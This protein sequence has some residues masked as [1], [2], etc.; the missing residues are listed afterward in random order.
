MF[1]KLLLTLM[2]LL[3]PV[4]AL[5][6]RYYLQ[7]SANPTV[8]IESLEKVDTMLSQLQESINKK[9]SSIKDPE[10]L[11]TTVFYATE[12]G[13]LT[14]SGVAPKGNLSVRVSTIEVG[15]KTNKKDAS[16]SAV[17]G[18]AITERAINTSQDGV[19]S[20]EYEVDNNKLDSVEMRFEQGQASKTVV[21]NFGKKTFEQI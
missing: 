10:L 3:L 16:E 6:T 14:V 15:S 5:L 9:E 8:T 19:F 13:V 11:V 17:L 21:Y 12:S 20:Y 7:K 1:D 2:L 4:S 18:E